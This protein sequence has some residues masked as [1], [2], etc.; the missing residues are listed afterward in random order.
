MK[1][2]DKVS[3]PNGFLALIVLLIFISGIATMLVSGHNINAGITPAPKKSDPKIDSS[4]TASG[5]SLEG[6]TSQAASPNAFEEESNLP[7]GYRVVTVLNE[8][9]YKGPQILVNYRYQSMIDGE[10][11]V[12]IYDNASKS[13]GVKDDDMFI[14]E[15]IVDPIN[16]FFDDFEKAKG[17]TSI[18]ISSSY[19]SKA[20]QTQIYNDSVK[21]TGASSTAYYV[22]IPGFSEHQTGYCFDTAAYNDDGEM[23]ELDGEGDFSWLVENCYKYGLIL[24]Y[25]DDKTNITGIGYE[26]WHFRYVGIPHAT[27]INQQ[28]I[29]LEEYIE[30]IKDYTFENGGLFIDGGKDSGKWVVYYMHKLDAFNNTDIPVPTDSAK[31]PY[32]ISGNNIDGFIV[33]VDVTKD[34]ANALLNNARK[35]WNFDC[36]SLEIAD[37][38]DYNPLEDTESDKASRGS[39]KNDWESDPFWD[40]DGRS[41]DEGNSES[42]DENDESSFDYVDYYDEYEDGG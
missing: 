4:D 21:E 38:K 37:F 26:A 13:V 6:L 18:L 8:D 2:T 27:F 30:G 16:S 14:N 41:D 15:S 28:K 29:C 40:E 1:K 9:I 25:P 31:C 17:K 5:N 34:P 24:R 20:D 39:N 3:V 23:V 32:T 19:R 11:L 35:D 7:A 33:T 42:E 12:N 36:T 10:N 22:A